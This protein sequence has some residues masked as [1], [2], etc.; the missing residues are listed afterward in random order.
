MSDTTQP[1]AS[2]IPDMADVNSTEMDMRAAIGAVRCA[3][4]PRQC[5]VHFRLCDAIFD[6][7]PG[8]MART[9]GA[10]EESSPHLHTVSDYLA[11]TMLA[12][13]GHPV[14]C[15]L[16]AIKCMPCAG[17]L[18]DESF[19]ILVSADFTFCHGISSILL[20]PS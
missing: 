13:R 3:A 4:V 11:F 5:S 19:V 7:S 17:R 9:I 14:Y 18:D 10:A 1:G 8:G 2:M 15:A 16:E 6:V 12:N 20:S